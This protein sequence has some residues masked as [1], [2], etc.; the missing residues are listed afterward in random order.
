M[1]P[2]TDQRACA[3]LLCRCH[4]NILRMR[5]NNRTA[6]GDDETARTCL[7]IQGCQN[8]NLRALYTLSQAVYICPVPHRT[9]S[10]KHA[11]SQL[12]PHISRLPALA[13]SHPCPT[14]VGAQCK[15]CTQA[16]ATHAR[17]AAPRSVST[18][19]YETARFIII[20]MHASVSKKAH[21]CLLKQRGHRPSSSH[22]QPPTTR[23]PSTMR[24]RNHRAA[25]CYQWIGRRVVVVV[26]RR[27]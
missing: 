2:T 23:C 5:G 14:L 16:I 25:T 15:T 22:Q 11:C 21:A 4:R 27:G 24:G 19:H 12:H 18:P 17:K 3:V 20:H 7:H 26:A 6:E 9:W 1:I 13:S 10:K 8:P